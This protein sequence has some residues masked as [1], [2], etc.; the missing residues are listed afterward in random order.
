MLAEHGRPGRLFFYVGQSAPLKSRRPPTLI[1]TNQQVVQST[2]NCKPILTSQHNSSWLLGIGQ[3]LSLVFLTIMSS[4]DSKEDDLF[5]FLVG[6]KEEDR[7]TW[8]EFGLGVAPEL[9]EDVTAFLG[10]ST[11]GRWLTLLVYSMLGN[12][13]FFLPIADYYEAHT[14]PFVDCVLA[15][16]LFFCPL[17]FCI[18][19]GSK[20]SASY[21]RSILSIS[22]P[23]FCPGLNSLILYLSCLPV[24]IGVLQ[25][26]VCERDLLWL[27]GLLVV[28]LVI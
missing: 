6:V 27:P 22:P 4:A 1:I 16:A 9:I 19:F 7:L 10:P 17:I 12:C 24:A 23:P 5:P 26:G 8:E 20:S 14:C 25:S 21:I 28:V 13:T 15:L 3:A 2:N 18:I 11:L